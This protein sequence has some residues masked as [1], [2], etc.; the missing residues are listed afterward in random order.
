MKNHQFRTRA[1]HAGQE[2]DAAT[3][4]T[5]IPIHPSTTFTQSA[6]GEHKGYEYSRTGNPTRAALEECLASLEGGLFGAAFA[7]G[8]AAMTAVANLLSPGDNLIVGAEVY[9]GTYRLFSGVFERWGITTTYVKS[10]EAKDFAKAANNKTRMIWIETPTNPLL[11]ILDISSLVEVFKG[12]EIMIVVDNTFAT[13]YLQ[14]P[15][16]LGADVVVYSTTKYLN[17]HSDV[18]GGIVI[19][20]DKT[21]FERVKYYQNAAG[22]VPSPFDCWLLLRGLKTLAARM[23]AHQVGAEKVAAFLLEHPAVGKVLYPGLDS[24]K[25][26]Q[27]AKKQM[28]GWGGMISMEVPDLSLLDRFFRSLELFAVAESLGGVESLACHPYS[29]THA[30]MPE[31]LR[32][33]VGITPG[34]VR[35]SVGLEDPNDLVADLKYALE[36]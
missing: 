1:I 4:S 22:A 18:V 33:A 30:S 7:S 35:L 21:L 29:M 16:S 17:G 23:E 11:N 25:G 13:P 31:D 34:L 12:S 24:H 6:P 10:R 28:S 15:L 20:S 9:G 2:A 36:P 32:E 14:K 8:M 5:I 3:G 19:T 27:L 26:H